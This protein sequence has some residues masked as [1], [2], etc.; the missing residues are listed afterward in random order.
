MGATAIRYG[1]EPGRASYTDALDRVARFLLDL[2][3]EEHIPSRQLLDVIRPYQGPSWEDLPEKTLA[4]VE[5][6]DTW[7]KAWLALH[8]GQWVVIYNDLGVMATFSDVEFHTKF[9]A[10]RES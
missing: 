6:F 8:P 7:R 3:E 1:N 9:Y 10:N 2:S 5:V 4:S